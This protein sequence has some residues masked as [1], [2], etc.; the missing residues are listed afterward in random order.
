MQEQLLFIHS[1]PKVNA[2]AITSKPSSPPDK[3]YRQFYQFLPRIQRELKNQEQNIVENN[4][5]ILHTINKIKAGKAS[6][7]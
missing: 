2:L 5:L 4:F 7:S 3:E 6:T 1:H